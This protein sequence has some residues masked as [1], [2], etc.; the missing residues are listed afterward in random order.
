MRYAGEALMMYAMLTAKHNWNYLEKTTS[1]GDVSIHSF[2][3]AID[4]Q[5]RC[6]AMCIYKFFEKNLS[7]EVSLTD[8]N[9]VT[10]LT[11]IIKPGTSGVVIKS[12]KTG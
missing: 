9:C 7:I 8:K 4:D 12:W 3:W 11:S 5:K 10:K 1:T 2:L 6:E